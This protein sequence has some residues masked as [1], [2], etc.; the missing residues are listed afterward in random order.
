M[1]QITFAVN[2]MAVLR[3]LIVGSIERACIFNTCP[4]NERNAGMGK[5]V[6]VKKASIL[7]MEVM[8]LN[9]NYKISLISIN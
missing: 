8:R 9:S 4:Q 3:R 6:P 5:I 2:K 1:M 7:L